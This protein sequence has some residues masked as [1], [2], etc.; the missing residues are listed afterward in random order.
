HGPSLKTLKNKVL[1]AEWFTFYIYSADKNVLQTL[2]EYV[3]EGTV[4]VVLNWGKG[5]PGASTH[6]FGQTLSINE[7]MYRNLYR[8]KYLVY[9]DLDEFIVPR[10]S[11]GW[12]TL[13]KELENPQF[14]TFVFRHAFFFASYNETAFDANAIDVH[15]LCDG[16]RFVE[17]P[18]FLTHVVRSQK[19][20][21][22]RQKSK[23]ITKPLYSS[24]VGVHEIFKHVEEHITSHV[25]PTDC[26]LLHHYRKFRGGLHPV[27]KS[28]IQDVK[29]H[30][31]V[32]DERALVYKDKIVAAL[33]RRLCRLYAFE[34]DAQ[35]WHNAPV[36][37]T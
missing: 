10:K 3:R 1:G 29:R 11:L 13:M 18:Q 21:P 36:S 5:L 19:V 20:Y 15:V 34:T 31:R 14:G 8:V 4:E 28:V 25:V 12:G 24:V 6:Y 2:H 33:R 30:Q 17:L 23:F 16:S 27:S 7:C 35:T 26:A 9:A 22:S 32:Q 37:L